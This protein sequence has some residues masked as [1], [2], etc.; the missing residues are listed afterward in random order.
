[1]S[2]GWPGI[3]QHKDKRMPYIHHTSEEEPGDKPEFAKVKQGWNTYKVIQAYDKNKEG[4][5]LQTRNGT[6]F[7]RL[8]CEDPA[9]AR[10][11]YDLF[12]TEKA[13]WKIDNMLV[14]AG[15]HFSP[16]EEISI[17]PDTFEG[18]TFRGLIKEITEWPNIDKVA[19][20]VETAE[21]APVE[22]QEGTSEAEDEDINE[23]VPF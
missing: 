6:D 8:R 18:A 17:T 3:F 7:I 4:Q 1:M 10:I 5:P 14:A 2:W 15:I 9:G 23:T 12:L 19:P 20:V 13:A 16:G 11:N 21:E 22:A